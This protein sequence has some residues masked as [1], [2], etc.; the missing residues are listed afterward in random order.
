MSFAFYNMFFSVHK[1]YVFSTSAAES[2]DASCGDVE[3]TDT[4]I[5][6]HTRG[7][8]YTS[9]TVAESPALPKLPLS[10]AKI[11]LDTL[12]VMDYDNS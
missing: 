4:I 12:R 10:D 7:D 9:V 6:E 5:A 3:M 11:P 2:G 8:D 1:F